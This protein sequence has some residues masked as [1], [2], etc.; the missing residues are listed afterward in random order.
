MSVLL[1]KTKTKRNRNILPCRV[2]RLLAI[3]LLDRLLRLLTVL[4]HSSPRYTSPRS[5]SCRTVVYVSLLYVS[6]IVFLLCC[7]IR[8]LAIRGGP[9]DGQ[10]LNACGDHSLSPPP[11]PA[12]SPRPMFCSVRLERGCLEQACAECRTQPIVRVYTFGERSPSKQKKMQ[13]IQDM[14]EGHRW[15]ITGSRRQ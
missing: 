4:Y 6:S 12:P 2:I 15:S 11:P 5:S 13:Q 7:A 1:P 3:R 14:G 10:A 9:A 8:L